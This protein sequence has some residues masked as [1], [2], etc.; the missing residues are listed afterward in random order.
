M[1]NRTI[2]T[3]LGELTVAFY[4]AALAE[5][6]DEHRAAQLAQRM[7]RAAVRRRRVSV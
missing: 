6:H 7:M 5:L 2:K 3:T 1:S 4:E